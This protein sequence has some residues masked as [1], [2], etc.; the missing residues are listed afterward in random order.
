M[1]QETLANGKVEKT[2]NEVSK[3]I[4]MCVVNPASEDSLGR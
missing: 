3:I 4:S 1:V 2:A